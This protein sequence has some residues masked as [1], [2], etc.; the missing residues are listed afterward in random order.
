MLLSV[1]VHFP[2]GL[3]W[4][5]KVTTQFKLHEMNTSILTHIHTFWRISFKFWFSK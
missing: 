1:L 3:Q 4:W 5:S 2:Q